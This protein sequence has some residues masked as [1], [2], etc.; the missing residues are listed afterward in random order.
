MEINSTRFNIFLL[1][2]ILFITILPANSQNP[3][4]GAGNT[5]VLDGVNDFVNGGQGNR[6]I[7]NQVTVEAWIKTSALS[8]QWIVGKYS[9]TQGEDAG[10][11]LYIQNGRAF[12]SGRDGSANYRSSGM[13]ATV[14]ADNRWHHLT[15]VCQNGRWEIWVDGIL[16]NSVSTGYAH[17]QLATSQPPLTIGNYPT[18]NENYFKGQI[19]EVRIWKTG[20]TIGE[21]RKFMCQKLT[22]KE[23][24]LVAYFNADEADNK[25]LRDL[26]I[27]GSNGQLQNFSTPAHAISG[28]PLGDES[29]DFYKIGAAPLPF[30]ELLSNKPTFQVFS[31]SPHAEGVHLYLVNGAP[32]SR[33]GLTGG[34]TPDYYYGVFTVAPGPEVRYTVNYKAYQTSSCYALYKRADNSQPAWAL[35]PTLDAP[36]AY[37]L[38]M[39]G[40]SYRGEYIL[41]TNEVPK[42]TLS[43]PASLCSGNTAMLTAAGTGT[44][45][46]LWNTGAV[47]ATIPIDKP[48]TYSVRFTLPGGCYSEM[49][50]T[51][52]TGILPAF[53]LGAD[54]VLC[55]GDTFVLKAPTGAGMTYTW[56]DG[57]TGASFTVNQSGIY[58]LEIVQNGCR[59]RDS[60]SVTNA[61][62]PLV[63][64]G[65]DTTLCLGN[66]LLLS[67]GNPGM[68]Y[69]WQDNTT[70]STYTVRAP[71]NY[72]VDVE[73]AAGCITRGTIQV[74]YLSP[75]TIFLGNDTTLCAGQTLI[76]N[77]SLP[78][79]KY[80]WQDGS[81]LADFT[82]TRPGKYWLKASLDVCSESDTLTVSYLPPP[83]VVFSGDTV[84]CRGTTLLLSALTPGATYHWQDGSTG[85][86]ML[87]E[88]EG[89]YWVTVRRGSCITTSTRRVSYEDCEPFIPN[90]ITPNA[91]ALN[92]TFFIRNIDPRN[93]T[94]EIY[95][96]WGKRIYQTSS[97][98]NDWAAKNVADGIYYY[99]LS[100][101]ARQRSYKGYLEVLR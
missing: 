92:E 28:A 1:L 90:I 5:L 62:K 42:L 53:S 96:R 82:I 23:A 52:S 74:A 97:Y 58:W 85:A 80:L 72:W 41:N 40:E 59:S 66:T 7:T 75:P 45:T 4:V 54:T 15:G 22:G 79:V 38:N 9:N 83:P 11:H 51:I 30:M 81:I 19:D 16:E 93:W 3:V 34:L 6:G 49:S 68:K 95:N 20:R 76:L 2:P 44:G 99:K 17:V 86:S 37:T 71:G 47:S 63:S 46:Y 21:I 26:S 35:L 25:I 67:A 43:G 78:G 55:A 84:L 64:L 10:Y 61:P 101:P 13:S 14:V 91:D 31:P 94:L 12:F 36:H 56:Q 65:P 98:A 24:N 89:D 60:V 73:N 48:G 39:P 87:A 57:S 33:N 29:K 69:R 70:A 8:Y 50:R 27:T 100:N 32:N 18:F 77:K 88:Q